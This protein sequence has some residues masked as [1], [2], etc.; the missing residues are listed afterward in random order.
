MGPRPCWGNQTFSEQPF[1]LI[2]LFFLVVSRSQVSTSHWCS[3]SSREHN[4][5]GSITISHQVH[6]HL[7][8]L[9]W[10]AAVRICTQGS[11]LPTACAQIFSRAS[12]NFCKS[13]QESLWLLS[14]RASISPSSEPWAS[15]DSKELPSQKNLPPGELGLHSFSFFTSFLPSAPFPSELPELPVSCHF[16]L[17]PYEWYSPHPC[18]QGRCNL[19]V[20]QYSLGN[21]LWF[22]VGGFMQQGST[23][24]PQALST[25]CVSGVW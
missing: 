10:L 8:L 25:R 15:I 2:R 7:E 11:S 20:N 12:Q 9:L 6:A 3:F 21:S 22:P 23:I 19:L 16:R 4:P 18:S 24:A 14:L 17:T 13:L 1:A 5:S